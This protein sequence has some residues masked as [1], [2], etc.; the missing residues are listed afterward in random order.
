MP[1]PPRA[2]VHD[3]PAGQSFQVFLAINAAGEGYVTV[4]GRIETGR[5]AGGLPG[6][7]HPDDAGATGGCTRVQLAL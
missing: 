5:G 1:R 6:C 3:E 7:H 4:H 2:R